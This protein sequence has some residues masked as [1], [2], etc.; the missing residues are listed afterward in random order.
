[1]LTLEMHEA[2]HGLAVARDRSR[3][4]QEGVL[5]GTVT[6]IPPEQAVGTEPDARSDL[7]SLGAMLYDGLLVLAVLFMATLTLTRMAEGGLF[8]HLGGGIVRI[9][10]H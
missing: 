2:L 6:Y 4:T 1:M 3:L 5:V 7:Y 10:E 9:T 8:D